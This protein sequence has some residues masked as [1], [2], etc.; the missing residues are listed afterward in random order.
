M[1]N[2]K[3]PWVTAQVQ[4]MK[5]WQYAEIPWPI[6]NAMLLSMALLVMLVIAYDLPVWLATALT[7]LFWLVALA[8]VV[9]FFVLMW[10]I[11][12]AYGPF[13]RIGG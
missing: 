1:V 7:A 12:A 2:K 5:R 3:Q 6:G 4:R 8:L 11:G 10:W 9:G 13:I